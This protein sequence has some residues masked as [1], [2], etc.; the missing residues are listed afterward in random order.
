M[1]PVALALGWMAYLVVERLALGRHRR[2]VPLRIAVTGTRGKTA[3]ARRLGAVLQEDGRRVLTKTTGAEASYLLPDETVREI[4]RVG[5]P[6]I[7]EQKRVLRLGARL[8]VE[9]VV[10]EIMSLHPE[11]HR[12]E[13]RSILK[14]QVVAVTNLRV[15]HTEAHGRTREEVASVLALDVPPGATAFVPEGEWEPVFH[16]LVTSGGGKVVGVPGSA[17]GPEP[18]REAQG[19][20]SME[21]G[22]SDSRGGAPAPTAP[23]ASPVAPGDRGIFDSNLDLVWAVARSLGVADE[24]I[25]RGLRRTKDD[26]GAFQ[27]FHLALEWAPGPWLAVN[28]FAANDPES[29]LGL[30]AEVKEDASLASKPCV[31]LLSLRGDRGDRSLL[32]ART[33]VSGALSEFERILVAGPHARALRFYLRRHPLAGRVELLRPS[34]PEG[35]M[36]QVAAVGGVEGGLLFGFGNFAGLGRDMVEYWRKVGVSHGT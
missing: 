10:A 23:P 22:A 5:N 2:A 28:A 25:R 30:L 27:G 12:V 1:I 6:S 4:R 13:A 29:T 34:S 20:G 15:D 14:P 3:V 16:D 36:K 24:V 31:G 35:V 21:V 19:A 17:S 7:I 32:W 33:L 26:L 8:G 11:N 9:V 18:T